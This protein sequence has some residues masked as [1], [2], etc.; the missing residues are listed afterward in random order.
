MIISI[1]EMSEIPIYQQIRNQIVQGISDG[2]L[3]P[4][5][6]LPTVRG[7]A[8][9]IGINSMTVNKAYSLLKQEGYIFADRR[10]GARVRKEFAVTKELSEK[11]KELLRPDHLGSESQRHDE[12]EFF[13]ICG[14]LYE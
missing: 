10:S 9:E 1:N 13:E 12:K 8:E 5:E 3:S 4:G 14:K 7:L 11:S 2:R 6:Q